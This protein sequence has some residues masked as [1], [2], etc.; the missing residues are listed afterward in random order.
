[1]NSAETRT[2]SN[3][4]VIEAV[5]LWS[6]SFLPKTGPAF[7]GNFLMFFGLNNHQEP[8]RKED[9]KYRAEKRPTLLEN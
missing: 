5:I 2:S 4:A 8:H 1:M 3:G 7:F 9:A 6:M